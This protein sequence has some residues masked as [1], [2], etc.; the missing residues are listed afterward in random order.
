MN[1]EQYLTKIRKGWDG[2]DSLLDNWLVSDSDNEI[3]L[4]LQKE[5]DLVR[6]NRVTGYEDQKCYKSKTKVVENLKGKI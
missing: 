4:R 5:T 3:K 1:F 2:E 6:W